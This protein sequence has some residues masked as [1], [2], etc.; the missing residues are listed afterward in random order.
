[1]VLYICRN[2]QRPSKVILLF[3][4]FLSSLHAAIALKPTCSLLLCSKEGQFQ[5]S[6]SVNGLFLPKLR[7]LNLETFSGLFFFLVFRSFHSHLC[8]LVF[9]LKLGLLLCN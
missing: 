1:M 6:F 9:G 4:E 8:R 3:M 7:P 5:C 2:T